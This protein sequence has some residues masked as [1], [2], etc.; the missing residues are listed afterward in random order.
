MGHFKGI[1]LRG[2]CIAYYRNN[3]IK[4]KS[5]LNGLESDIS[6]FEKKKI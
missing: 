6:A 5:K 1:Y 4:K 3:T 2:H